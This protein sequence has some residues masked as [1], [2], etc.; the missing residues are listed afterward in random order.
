MLR[1]QRGPS[2]S[3]SDL[4]NAEKISRLGPDVSVSGVALSSFDVCPG[5][6]FVGLQG[7]NCH[8]AEFLGD[9]VK[10]GAAALLTD[11][12]GLKILSVADIP[13]LIVEDPRQFLGRISARIYGSQTANKPKIFG[14]TGTNGKTS[15]AFLLEAIIRGL[16]KRTAISTTA[17]RQVDGVLYPSNLTTPES[18]DLHAMAAR[19][20]EENVWGLAIEISAQALVQNRLDGLPCDI[21]GFTNLS[22]DH[23]E[24]FGSMENYLRA[25]A[26]LFTPEKTDSAVVCVDTVWGERLAELSQVPL[27]KL[28]RGEGF[29]DWNYRIIQPV[30]GGTIFELNSRDRRSVQLK[31]PAIGI[32]MVANAALAAVMLIESGVEP[33]SLS[34]M[35]PDSLGIPV[36]IPGRM[37]KISGQT[38]PALYLDAGRSADA[39]SHTLSSLRDNT[40]GELIIV[41]GTSGNR[42]E[43]KRPIMGRVAASLADVV[44]VTDDDPR[45]ESPEKIRRG[46]LVGARESGKSDIHEIPNPIEAI[47]FAVSLAKEGDT[48][49]WTGPG[50]QDYRDV[51][52]EKIPFSA[53]DEANQALFDAGWRGDPK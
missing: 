52:G 14:V 16:G 28:G 46:L 7:A 51:G 24:D 45:R 10:S 4:A 32:H 36:L 6:L 22:H 21:A 3:L 44:I 40:E 38:G 31:L 11:N 26:A 27:V 30:D 39:Y 37:E 9:A 49:L 53:R 12:S 33:S 34:S 48:I 5:D 15:T 8:G 42:D 20:A 43:S 29:Y 2:V 1:P 23:F 25:K 47:R 18:P 19:A 41:C 35:G 17:N 50:S 13:A